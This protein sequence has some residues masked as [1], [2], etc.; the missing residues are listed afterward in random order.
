MIDRGNEAGI[1]KK[2]RG[3]VV[4]MDGVLHV[5][6]EPVESLPAFLNFLDQRAIQAVYVTN[7]STLTPKSLCERL[8]GFGIQADSS[9]II[10]SATATARYLSKEF[11]QGSRVLVVGEV[12][13]CQAVRD[14]GFKIV[15]DMP[16]AVVVGLD[17]KINYQKISK[18]ASAVLAGASFIACNIDS[19]A[20]TVSGI[21]PGAGAMVA[22]IQVVVQVAPVVIGKPE[23]TMFLEAAERMGLKLD[24]CAAI[25]DRLD[26]DIVSAKRA[27]M[28]GILVLSG[29]T[30]LDML[31]VSPHRPDLVYADIGELVSHWE[32]VF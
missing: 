16:Q 30:N 11:P 19:G 2:I 25:G 3:L 5:G 15:D 20:P 7:N 10:T 31:Q 23:S 27:G 26:I 12:G 22:A 14:M 28:L 32:M 29:M 17:R 21:A 6:P 8:S 24:E 4:D 1:L 18:A 13:L 9:Q